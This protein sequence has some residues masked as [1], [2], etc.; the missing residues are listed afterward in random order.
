MWVQTSQQPDSI[1]IDAFAARLARQNYAPRTIKNYRHSVSDFLAWWQRDPVEARRADVEA[2]LDRVGVLGGGPESVRTR[3]SALKRFFDYVDSM[4]RLVD[5]DGRE[6]R[7]PLDRIERPRAQRK[8]NDWLSPDEDAALMASPI[9]AQER[10]LL[11]L[12]RWSGMRVSEACALTWRDVDLGRG[13]LRVRKAKTDAGIRTIPVLPELERDLRD[14][15]RH[16]TERGLYDLDGP[17]LVTNRRTAM[18]TNHAWRRLKA[19]AARGG[20]RA[21]P[22]PDASGENVST[23]SPH[24]LRRTFA[25]DLLNRGVRIETVPNVLG[26]ANTQV[27]SVHYAEMLASTARDEILGAMGQ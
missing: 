23:I 11:G 15:L 2:Y 14:W 17:V 12:L 16:I 3:I 6:L 24:T 22:A 8:A 20:V 4:G 1:L 10:M 9:N 7:N 26:H 25:S 5:A 27:T 13:E 21:R 18:G 19:I